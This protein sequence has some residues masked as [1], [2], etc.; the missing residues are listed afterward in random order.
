MRVSVIIPGFNTPEKLWR[1]CVESV[2]AAGAD[3]IICVDDYSTYKPVFLREY[4][5]KLICRESNGGLA[6]AR[7][8]ALEL[9]TGEYVT[10]VDSDD[11]VKLDLFQRCKEELLR[12]KADIAVYGVSVIWPADGLYK[13]DSFEKAELLET[14]LPCDVLS[15]YNKCLLNYSCNKVY[16][17]SFLRFNHLAFKS[18]GMPCEDI[19]FNL[20]CIMSGA[21]LCTI[22]YVGYL[23][24]RTRGTLLSRY[25]KTL[26]AGTKCASEA[27]I[28]YKDK[29][30]GARTTLGMLGEM[31]EL[32]LLIAEWRNIWMPGTP[33]SII[34]RWKWLKA[35][36]QVGGVIC[37]AR[38]AIFVL[39]RRFC[40][41]RCIRRWNTRKNYPLARDWQNE[42]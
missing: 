16:R 30:P 14:V 24:Y 25:K 1:R 31:T 23:Y 20:E 34:E 29:V 37:F 10:F 6:V 33:Y 9:A 40:Y 32:Q 26:L 42:R 17:L 28:A 19:V 22:P 41:L 35:H 27:W 11:E 12:T 36:P 7:N 18:D 4:P 2:I 13:E 21:R 3:E 5:V 15:M 8:T 39:L 38:M